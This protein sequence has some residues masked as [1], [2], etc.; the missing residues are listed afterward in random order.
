MSQPGL[1]RRILFAVVLPLAVALL[2][3]CTYGPSRIEPPSID[4]SAA[5]DMAI[6]QYDADGDGRI[7]GDELE[8][9]ITLKAA[10]ARLDTDGDKAVSADEVT[11]RVK[12]WQGTRLGLLPLTVTVTLNGRPLDGA[13]VTFEP[14]AFLGEEVKKAV[15]STDEFGGSAPTVAKEERPDPQRTPAGVALGL[16]RVRIS[17]LVNGKEMVPPKYNQETTLGQEVAPDVPELASLRLNYA[18][19]SN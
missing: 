4:A 12:V 6:E 17:K 7:A 13:T 1:S 11:Q 9:A 2:A 19:R 14:E 3:S 15:G 18:L 5:G 16:Y 8:K 10:V